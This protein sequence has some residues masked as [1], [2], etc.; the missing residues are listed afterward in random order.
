MISYILGSATVVA[1]IVDGRGTEE[2]L[3]EGALGQRE[4]AHDLVRCDRNALI[5]SRPPVN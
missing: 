5:L 2:V 1:T 3:L 4:V